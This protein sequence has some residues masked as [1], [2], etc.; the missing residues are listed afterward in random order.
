MLFFVVY[1]C[2]VLVFGDFV[3]MSAVVKEHKNHGLEEKKLKLNFDFWF[4]LQ[5][6]QTEYLIFDFVSTEAEF[7]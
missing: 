2:V 4:C 1:F 3:V 7:A 5:P 6:S